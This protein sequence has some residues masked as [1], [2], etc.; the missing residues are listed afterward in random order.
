MDKVTPD[1]QVLSVLNDI[2]KA[3][4]QKFADNLTMRE[5]VK[6]IIL[7]GV[8]FNGTLKPGE[9]AEPMRNFALKLGVNADGLSPQEL[10][11]HVNGVSKAVNLLE[12]GFSTINTLKSPG[13]KPKEKDNPGR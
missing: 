9:P 6:K 7:Y 5:A 4:L 11:D 10:L 12:V 1:Q 2:E 3:E 13:P 8:Y